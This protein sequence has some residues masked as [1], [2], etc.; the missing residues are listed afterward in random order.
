[1]SEPGEPQGGRASAFGFLSRRAFL[2]AGLGTAAG[3]SLALGLGAT[4]LVALR[5]CAPDVPG[6]TILS[7]HQYRTLANLAR[8]HLP[9]GGPFPE[10]A[11]DFDLAR[12][13][14]GF[15]ADEAPENIGN[16][17]LALALVEVGP[18]LFEGRLATFS[19]LDEAEQLAHWRGWIESDD[20]VRRQA[21]L[22]FRKFLSLVF[23]DQPRVWPHIG[24]PGPRGAG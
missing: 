8:V 7:A 2:R 6:L 15:L 5:G 21:A 22:A 19:N 12:M 13:F 23:Y 4:G 3:A 18:V 20:L 17:K 10:G 11:E 14:D 1:M 9:R 24:Y 16:L